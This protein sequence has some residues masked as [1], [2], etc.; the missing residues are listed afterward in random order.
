ME[1]RTAAAAAA[2]ADARRSKFRD[3]DGILVLVLAGWGLNRFWHLL[4]LLCFTHVRSYY[5][6]C[7]IYLNATQRLRYKDVLVL[8]LFS[9]SFSLN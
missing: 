8:M 1:E 9:S 6:L 4:F 2:A 3:G 5:L 7:K